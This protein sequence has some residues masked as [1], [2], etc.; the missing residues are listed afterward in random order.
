[1]TNY[2]GQC[3]CKRVK[4]ECNGE[5]MF[6]QYCHCNK[7]REIALMSNSEKDKVGYSYTAAYLIENFNVTEG[8]DNLEPV[9]R[10]NAR[11]LLCSNCKSLIYGIS[12]DPDKQAGIGINVN[13]FY[14]ND[15]MP[16]S[17]KPVRHTWYINRVVNF[18]DDLPKFK[19][20]PKEQF[21]SGELI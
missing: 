1:M 2:F 16:E 18:D 20:V 8:E 4:F 10:Q 17:F 12:I 13:N 3:I 21:G 7:C 11:L 14:F 15:N 9:I 5:P 19:D 6:T